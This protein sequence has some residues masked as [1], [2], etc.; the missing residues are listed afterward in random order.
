[1]STKQLT[2]LILVSLLAVQLLVS[3]AKES[4]QEVASELTWMTS[5]EDAV[6]AAEK[7]KQP[8]MIDFY[9]DWC[10]WCKRLD[11]STYVDKDV[12]ALAEKFVSL[13]IDADVERSLSS[14][15]KV[16]GLPTILFI[17]ASGSELHRVV[18]FR[19][20]ADFLNEMNLA[21]ESHQGKRGS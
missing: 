13:K 8:I 12:V 9:A 5:Y 3:C 7:N 1:M 17:D 15:H 2:A 10:G 4:K 11:S 18:G 20:P 14:Q 19:S 16:V 21:L 6:T